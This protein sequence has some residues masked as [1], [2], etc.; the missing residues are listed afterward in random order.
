MEDID[1]SSVPFETL[2]TK[3]KEGVVLCIKEEG[4]CS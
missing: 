4:Q 2:G 3:I 1:R